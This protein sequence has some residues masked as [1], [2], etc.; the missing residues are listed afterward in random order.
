MAIS[1]PSAISFM[2]T[3]RR[4][5]N[6]EHIMEKLEPRKNGSQMPK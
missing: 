1:N 3:Q 4:N 2:G 6:P 5:L